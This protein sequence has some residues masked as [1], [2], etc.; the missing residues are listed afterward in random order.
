MNI[1]KKLFSGFFGVLFLLGIITAFSIVQIQSINSS[2]TELVE[3]Q[4]AKVLLAKEMKYQVSEESR[5]LR[6]YVTTGADSALQSYKS[7]SEQ[8]YAAAEELGTL[9]ES[10]PA[11]EM[12]DELK[13]FQAEYN[14]AAEQIIVYQAEGNTDGYNQLFANV[15]VPLTAQ[16]SEKAIELEEYNQAELD[17]G[18][19]DTT[20]QAAEARNFI[21]IV[22][23]I[24]LLIGVAIALYISRIISKPVIEVAEAAEQIADGNLSIQ[25]VQ[26]K[27]KDEIGAMA[28]SFNQMKQNLRELIRKV[29]EGAEQVA[30]SSEELSAASE[31]SSQS[32][33]Q[34]AEAVQ[35]ISGAA[36]GQIRSMEENKRVMDE[37]AVGLQQMAESVV[38]VSESTQEVLKEAEQ[39][40]LVIDQTIRQMQGVN[41]SVKETAVVIQSL[42]ENSKQI[43]QIVQ[44]ISDIAN[45]TNLLA[46]NAAI[47]AARAGEHGKVLR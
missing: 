11:K 31:Q 21:L 32:A 22:S 28:L 47:E 4:A 8:Y 3:E 25:D 17:Q 36:D 9:T 30:A 26:V 18:N 33:N 39:G 34:V 29:N 45:Q 6:G 43:G 1:R 46:L 38:A 5:H 35:D 44:V 15:I 16:F 13:G 2:Y 27:N 20:A 12:L 23:I 10:G 42:G 19:I 24:A 37:S 40:N 14:E 41:N 7:A